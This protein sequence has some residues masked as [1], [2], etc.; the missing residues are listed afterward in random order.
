LDKYFV[1]KQKASYLYKTT[2]KEFEFLHKRY[3]IA[4]AKMTFQYGGYFGFKVI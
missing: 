4:M 1:E 3:A 2:S